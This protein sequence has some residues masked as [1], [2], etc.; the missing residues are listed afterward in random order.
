MSPRRVFIVGFVCISIPLLLCLPAY[1][2]RG[3]FCE[4]TGSIKTWVELPFGIQIFQRYRRSALEEYVSHEM[5][6]ELRHRWESYEHIERNVIGIPL[7]YYCGRPIA[8]FG[9]SSDFLNK[10]IET[11][12]KAEIV[13]FHHTLL[14]GEEAEISARTK[15]IALWVRRGIES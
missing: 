10:W 2:T 9:L 13:E 4:V 8:L 1:T 5:P 14:R 3:D 15:A 6:H 12:P 7:T 11:K